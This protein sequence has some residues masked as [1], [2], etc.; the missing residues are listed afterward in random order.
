MM[1]FPTPG[2]LPDPW[3]ESTTCINCIGRQMLSHLA[4]WE[5]EDSRSHVKCF[6]YNT[7]K[8]IKRNSRNAGSNQ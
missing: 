3:M 2:D 4:T 1:P 8:E 7:N 6:N 5:T